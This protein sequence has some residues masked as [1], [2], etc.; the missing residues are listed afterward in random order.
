MNLTLNFTDNYFMGRTY[1][2]AG[3]SNGGTYKQIEKDEKRVVFTGNNKEDC[4]DLADT[5]INK[6]SSLS[7]KV[8]LRFLIE[9]IKRGVYN[10]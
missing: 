10:D 2:F 7:E 5:I 6:A 8:K 3:W 1:F 4:L 9:D